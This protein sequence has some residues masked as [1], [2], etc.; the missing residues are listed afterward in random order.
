MGVGLRLRH[1]GQDQINLTT[2][3]MVPKPALSYRAR[4]QT[5]NFKHKSF[6]LKITAHY[7]YVHNE[8]DFIKIGS[9]LHKLQ[10]AL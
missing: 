6:V 7:F 10:P 5:R 1:S 4:F 8:T 2:H 3:L 9:E